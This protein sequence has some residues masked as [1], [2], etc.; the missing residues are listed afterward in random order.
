MKNKL[1]TT[2]YVVTVYDTVLI[3]MEHEYISLPSSQHHFLNV[4]RNKCC[5]T[6]YLSKA[7]G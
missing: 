3:P 7:P 4:V 1:C 2:L 6:T 5:T